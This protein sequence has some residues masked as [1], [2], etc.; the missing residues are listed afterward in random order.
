[1]PRLPMLEPVG[2]LYLQRPHTDKEKDSVS[3]RLVLNL[4]SRSARLVVQGE[5]SLSQ[6]YCADES[7]PGNTTGESFLQWIIGSK[8]RS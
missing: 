1:M 2:F 8:H 4:I 3:I 5:I 7:T 6:I